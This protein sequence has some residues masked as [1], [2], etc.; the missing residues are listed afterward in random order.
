MRWSNAFTSFFPSGVSRVRPRHFRRAA[1][2][3]REIEE[4][5][6]LFQVAPGPAIGV[7][8]F[9]TGSFHRSFF[10]DSASGS[11]I[12]HLQG[13]LSHPYPTS[14]SYNEGEC[15]IT[16]AKFFSMFAKFVQN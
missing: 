8:E 9:V 4:L 5:F 13:F 15:L 1:F 6:D 3:A 2:Q 14:I 11:A 7:P 12:F 10:F 16:L